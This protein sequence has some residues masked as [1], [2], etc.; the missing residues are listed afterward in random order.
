MASNNSSDIAEGYVRRYFG[1]DK[2]AVT[3]IRKAWQG[4]GTGG[5]SGIWIRE[6]RIAVCSDRYRGL[7]GGKIILYGEKAVGCVD[8]EGARVGCPPGQTSGYGRKRRSGTDNY[9]YVT[10]IN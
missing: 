7:L 5:S 6:R 3:G 10:I 1:G 2:G 9:S 8:R 4:R